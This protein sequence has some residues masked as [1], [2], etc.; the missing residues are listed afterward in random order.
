MFDSE[1]FPTPKALG[2]RMLAP[3]RKLIKDGTISAVMDPQAGKG[4]LLKL[5]AGED[6][7]K[8]Y[9]L[10]KVPELRAIVQSLL[11]PSVA[12]HV[13][14]SKALVQVLGADFFEYTGRHK[15]DLFLMNPPFSD[16]PAHLLHAWHL[17]PP[18]GHIVCLLPEG[19]LEGDRLSN[20]AKALRPIVREHGTIESQ[21]TPFAA[22]DVERKTQVRVDLIRLQKPAAEQETF[23]FSSAAKAKNAMPVIDAQLYSNEIARNDVLGNLVT[24]YDNGMIAL[25]DLIRVWDRATFYL[26]PLGVDLR[27]LVGPHGQPQDMNTMVD[28]AQSAAWEE[29]ISKTKVNDLFTARMRVDFQKFRAE[30]G[31]LDFNLANIK[32]LFATLFDSRGTIASQCIQDVFD[33]LCSY[34]AKNKIHWEGWK[35]NSAHKVNSKVIIPWAIS[36]E[37]RWTN[38]TVRDRHALDDIDRAMCTVTGRPFDSIASLQAVLGTQFHARPSTITA[39]DIETTFFTAKC[40]KKGTLHLKFKDLKVWEAFNLAAAKGRG[41]L[42]A[43]ES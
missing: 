13:R 40:F 34:D 9:A 38:W 25:A 8:L 6:D 28:L 1:F 29:V 5:L 4:D 23:D 32:A 39:S 31:C 30:Q 10:E 14:R 36:Y 12:Y 37:S 35:T 20:A 33:K 43:S 16:G 19:A 42:G 24:C 17:A 27:D 7:L 22:Q 18:G 21:G 11:R 26:K 41:W 15:I 3:Y 2:L